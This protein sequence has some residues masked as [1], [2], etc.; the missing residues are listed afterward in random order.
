MGLDP[1]ARNQEL[2]EDRAERWLRCIVHDAPNMGTDSPQ[3]LL[4]KLAIVYGV[5][6][7]GHGG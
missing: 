7:S 2:D 6:N 3:N 1:Y 4:A 5:K